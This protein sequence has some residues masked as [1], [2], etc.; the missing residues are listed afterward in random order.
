MFLI[1]MVK[2]FF[3]GL[4]YKDTREVL[5][6]GMGVVNFLESEFGK[7]FVEKNVGVKI[8]QDMFTGKTNIRFSNFSFHGIDIFADM[9]ICHGPDTG[10]RII[11]RMMNLEYVS[12]PVKYV[13]VAASL[14]PKILGEY[15]KSAEH[16]GIYV[17][18]FTAHTKIPEA[19]VKRIYGRDN[20]DDVIYNLGE[21]AC[22]AGCHA[23]VLEGERLKNEKIAKLPIKK[24]V[25]GIRIDASD[26]GTQSR[27]TSLNELSELKEKADY[28]VVSSRYVSKPE[29]LAGYF[30]ALL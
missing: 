11:D 5:D 26:R 22:E 9:K 16:D 20:L 1:N 29:S 14:G 17:I 8:N 4:D 7:D 27:V 12:I 18:A 6:R 25:T 30:K 2:K 3:L 21:I 19:D 23:M 10:E 24:L 13:T 15:V 28:V